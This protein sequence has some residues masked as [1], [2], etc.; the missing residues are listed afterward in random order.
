M[1]DVKPRFDIRRELFEWAQA[2]VSAIVIFVLIF[3]FAFRVIGVDGHSMEPTLLDHDKTMI[4]NLF[5]TPQH[6][7]VIMF[8]KKGLQTVGREPDQPFVKRIIGLPGDTIDINFDTNEV[9]VNGVLLDEPYINAPTRTSYD[10]KF[11]VVVPDGCVFVMGDNRN[12]SLDSRSSDVG[13]IDQRYILGRVIL[14][15]YPFNKIKFV[16]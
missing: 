13:M 12:I 7:D 15:V 4:S 10:V 11:P 9:R 5:Y 2:L 14:R 8:N 6:G 3:T 16:K 1:D